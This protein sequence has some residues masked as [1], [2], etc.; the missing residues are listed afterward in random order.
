MTQCVNRIRHITH[1][2]TQ[3]DRGQ[4]HTAAHTHNT[5]KKK[6]NPFFAYCTVTIIPTKE[7]RD[8]ISKV[9]Y[10]TERERI[11]LIAI[12][13]GLVRTRWERESVCVQSLSWCVSVRFLFLFI[14]WVYIRSRELKENERGRER[15]EKGEIVYYSVDSVV[16]WV[17]RWRQQQR[18]SG[19]V[20]ILSDFF[21]LIWRRWCRRALTGAAAADAVTGSCL[22]GC[23]QR[24]ASYSFFWLWERERVRSEL[25]RERRVVCMREMWGGKWFV[26]SSR[27]CTL[28]SPG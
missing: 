24:V 14:F 25:R 17:I 8:G 21:F 12:R 28:L 9:E 2:H 6:E 19:V 11:N 18:H 5:Q 15:E 22:I 1:T 4:R 20:I 10:I 13:D 16:K 3:R 26:P 27:M 23:R 7:N